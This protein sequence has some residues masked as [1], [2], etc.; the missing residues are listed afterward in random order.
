MFP[1]FLIIDFDSTF[2]SKESLDELAYYTLQKSKV[3]IS[4]IEEIQKITD[5]GMNGEITFH[6]SIDSR[7]QLMKANKS[8]VIE[9]S[10]R[11]KDYITP[12]F[13]RNKDFIHEHNKKIYFISGGFREMLLP[14]LNN[15]GISNNHIFGNEFTYDS[16]N[17]IV[18]FEK[19]NPLTDVSGKAKIL[20]S[21]CLNGEIHAIGDG[22]NDYKLKAVGAASKFFAFTE[23]IKRE[24]VCALADIVLTSFDEYIE[25]FDD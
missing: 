2:I 21:L 17:N 18:G 4:V 5:A 10:N 20:K 19:N 22:Y 25:I 14:V 15:F 9:I 12:S 24:N 23:N 6:K 11:L 13:L 16:D 1:D 3:D 7:L 8:D